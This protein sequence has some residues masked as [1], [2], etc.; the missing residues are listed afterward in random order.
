MEDKHADKL[1]VRIIHA[2]SKGSKLKADKGI[3][4]PDS[5]L[6][7]SGL[8]AKDKE[9]LKFIAKH[10]DVVNFLFVN[11]QEDVKDMLKELEGLGVKDKLGII[12]KIETQKG[13]DNLTRILFEAMKSN[14]IGVMFARGDLA[15]EAGWNRIGSIQKEMLAICNACHV[16]VV[17][18]TQVLENLAKK[19]LPSR[20]KI[21][22][23]VSAAK[24]DCVMLNKGQHIVE[25]IKLLN[26][27]IESSEIYED[28]N[29]PMLPKLK[30]ISK[31]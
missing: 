18:A 20:S 31:Q 3:N 23:D 9:D 16:S 13:E 8:T 6:K 30:K 12:L 21:T 14:R 15:I 19:G 28:N 11:R 7:I 29:A 22:D 10:A 17:L 27:L 4:F 2:K 1:I 24:A 26:Q 25:A 5:N